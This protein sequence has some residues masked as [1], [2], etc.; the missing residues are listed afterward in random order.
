MPDSPKRE[1]SILIAKSST[2]IKKFTLEKFHEFMESC[3]DEMAGFQMATQAEL[4][5]FAKQIDKKHDDLQH[6]LEGEFMSLSQFMS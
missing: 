3:K 2:E 1:S 5:R 4:E 6:T